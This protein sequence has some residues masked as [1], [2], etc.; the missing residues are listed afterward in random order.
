MP[1]RLKRAYDPPSDDDGYRILVERL[2]PRGLSKDRAKIDLWIKEA[3]A[4]HELRKWFGHDPA[5][6]DEFRKRYVE[7]IE[8]KQEIITILRNALRE[9][10]TVTFVYS[11]RDTEH[12]NAVA[13]KEYLAEIGTG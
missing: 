13:L 4:S 5:R 1:I 8:Q 7:E 9:K 10:E 12:N 3:G 6:W 2:W 11:A